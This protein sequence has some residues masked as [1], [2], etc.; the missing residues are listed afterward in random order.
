MV[1][2]LAGPILIPPVVMISPRYLTSVWWNWH[3]S[4]FKLVEACFREFL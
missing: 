4:G 1:K 2:T 3:F